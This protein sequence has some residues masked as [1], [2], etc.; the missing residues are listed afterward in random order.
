MACLLSSELAARKRKRS[1]RFISSVHSL[2][3]VTFLLWTREMQRMSLGPAMWR[4]R[5]AEK[6][7]SKQAGHKTNRC[8]L[9]QLRHCVGGLAAL[10]I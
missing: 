10:G 1:F 3:T 5:Q 7:V 2:R 6:H 9:Q 4:R 8:G